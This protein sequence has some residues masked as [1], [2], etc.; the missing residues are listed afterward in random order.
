MP[1]PDLEHGFG[2]T[3]LRDAV[4]F[5]DMTNLNISYAYRIHAGKHHLALGLL[6]GVH[7]F[8]SNLL[9]VKTKVLGDPAFF[10]NQVN[11]WLPNAGAGV[12]YNTDKLFA[13]F[14]VPNILPGRLNPVDRQDLQARRYMYM[15]F[16]GG[17]IVDLQ[18]GAKF[19]PSMMIRYAPGIPVS[20]D[21]T[22]SFFLR[23]MLWVGASWRYREA[24]VFF[25]ELQYRQWRVGYSYDFIQS[26]ISAFTTGSHEIMLSFDIG[27]TKD[28]KRS[29]RYF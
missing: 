5:T 24:F 19:R 26:D 6:G 14:A 20:M 21:L 7:H 12:Y 27:F 2:F 3:L 16:N 28:N 4:G 1:S 13:G 25:A 11:R 15:N 29:P 10:F 23:D 8:H 17:G 18:N 9:I 22:G